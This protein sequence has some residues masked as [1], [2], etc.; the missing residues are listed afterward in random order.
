MLGPQPRAAP[1]SFGR[2]AMSE[3]EFL[4][5]KYLLEQLPLC[6]SKAQLKLSVALIVAALK[7]TVKK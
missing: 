4:D 5:F 6:K 2:F 1:S 3:K 7:D